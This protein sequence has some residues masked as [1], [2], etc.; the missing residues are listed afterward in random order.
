M[1]RNCSLE[2]ISDGRLYSEN[3]MVRADTGSCAGCRSVCCHGMGQS[4][5]LDPYDVFRLTQATGQPFDVL[6]ADRIEISRV[7]GV[8]LPN[9]KMT[10]NGERCSFLNR[11]GRCLIHH[12]RPAV[13]R[14]FP[15]GRYWTDET[16]FKYILQ[17]GQCP[18]RNLKK[19]KVEKWLDTPE[20][21][22]YNTFVVLW[23]RYVKRIEAA[24]VQI[25]S[26]VDAA[27]KEAEALAATQIKTICLYTLKSF[28]SAPYD[29]GRSFYGQFC[30]RLELAYKALGMDAP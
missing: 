27:S 18:K 3:D 25:G 1:I 12:A 10:A 9:L 22:D 26:G 11:D 8:L 6:L 16:H 14:L 7:D 24:V 2:E 4:V 28:Y 17:T 30:R 29:A 15:L 21:E 5:L 23:H 20:L 13:C 19:V